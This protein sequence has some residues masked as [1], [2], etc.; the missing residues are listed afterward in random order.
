MRIISYCTDQLIESLDPSSKLL[1]EDE[2]TKMRDEIQK[3]FSTNKD[4]S[5][6]FKGKIVEK[7]GMFELNI[8]TENIKLII[9]MLINLNKTKSIEFT[10]ILEINLLN[11][12]ISALPAI[13][14]ERT[15]NKLSNDCCYI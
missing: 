14:K 7:K 5:E 2:L 4:K 13:D 1:R 3:S 12:K 15:L 10:D 6:N 11:A 9:P 8:E